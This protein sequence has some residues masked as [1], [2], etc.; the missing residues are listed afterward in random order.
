MNWLKDHKP[1]FYFSEL[2][3]IGQIRVCYGK[4]AHA[5]EDVR[6]DSGVVRTRLEWQQKQKYTRR[7]STYTISTADDSYY[8]P[9][10]LSE[11][12]KPKHSAGCCF[13]LFGRGKKIQFVGQ[14][15][16]HIT[17]WN[18]L[19]NSLIQQGKCKIE[20]IQAQGKKY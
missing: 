5:K 2:L 9:S 15:L 4:Y 3:L 19:I 18:I 7:P 12:L 13:L 14:K 11:A 6:S 20:A 16:N 8:S 10:A 1:K 17:N